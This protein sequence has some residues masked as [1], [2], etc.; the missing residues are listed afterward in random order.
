MNQRMPIWPD[1][2]YVSWSDTCTTLQLWTQIVGKIRLA[3]TPWLNHSWQVPLY[4]TA[5]GLGTSPMP[6]GGEILELEFDFR[7]HVLAARM[8]DGRGGKIAL[9]P[10]SVATFYAKALELLGALGVAV[11]LNDIPS[12]IPNPIRFSADHV[13]T[14]Y[15]ANA[16]HRFWRAVIQVDRVFKLFRTSFLGKV[17]PVHFFWGGFDLA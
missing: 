15:D 7:D 12:E 11:K 17:S 3:L 9:E 6:I 10:Q 8:S 14:S 13:H 4:V 16:A 2:D 1:M 5:R